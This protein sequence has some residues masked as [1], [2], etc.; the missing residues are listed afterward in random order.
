LPEGVTAETIE[1]LVRPYFE[2]GAEEVHV[3]V[4]CGRVF[5]GTMKPTHC[6]DHP[7]QQLSVFSYRVGDLGT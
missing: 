3:A 2:Q 6:Q 7:D 5:A 4:C 1:V